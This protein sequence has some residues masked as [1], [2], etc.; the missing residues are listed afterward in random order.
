MKINPDKLK[1]D[2]SV[3]NPRAVGFRYSDCPID[4]TCFHI[5][6]GFGTP[7]EICNHLKTDNDPAECIHPNVLQ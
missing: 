6:V 5:V 7:I 1:E 4:R 2:E 3:S